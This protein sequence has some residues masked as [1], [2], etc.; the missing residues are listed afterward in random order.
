MK[1][2]TGKTTVIVFGVCAVV[3]LARAIFELVYKTYTDS[4]FW[5]CANMVCTVL[6]IICFFLVLKKYRADKEK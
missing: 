4:V 1:K 6:W 3:W 5:F 2:K